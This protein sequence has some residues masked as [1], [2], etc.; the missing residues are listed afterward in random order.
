MFSAIF[1][2]FLRKLAFLTTN[3]KI[4]LN[5]NIDPW[6][7]KKVKFAL[8]PILLLRFTTPALLKFTTPRVA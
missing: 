6:I 4:F 2:D 8:E 1:V 5:N 3:G 7:L